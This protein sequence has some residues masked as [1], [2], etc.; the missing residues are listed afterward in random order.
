MPGRYS[1]ARRR[2]VS[3]GRGA[4]EG[5]RPARRRPP[6]PRKTI[7]RGSVLS[8]PVGGVPAVPERDRAAPTRSTTRSTFRRTRL[9]APIGAVLHS[10]VAAR[11]NLLDHISD[12][13]EGVRS[14]RAAVEDHGARHAPGAGHDGGTRAAACANLPVATRPRLCQRVPRSATMGPRRSAIPSSS[15]TCGASRSLRHA[16]RALRLDAV[17]AARHKAKS[18]EAG[19]RRREG[20]PPP[21]RGPSAWR[22]G[23]RPPGAPGLR[24]H[25]G[26]EVAH[27]REGDLRSPACC[28]ARVRRPLRG[29]PPRATP[30]D[31]KAVRARGARPPKAAVGRGCHARSC[32]PGQSLRAAS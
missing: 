23:A 16:P 25:G 27:G 6:R 32:R 21:P 3:R 5:P 9:A 24:D 7:D 31:P 20:L 1:P 4:G 28:H 8:A 14:L 13:A 19:G 18:S 2:S 12:G 29:R 11:R 30:S 22:D 26:V 10:E 15:R 17:R